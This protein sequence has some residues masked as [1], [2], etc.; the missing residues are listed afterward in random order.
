[1]TLDPTLAQFIATGFLIWLSGYG[2]GIVWRHFRQIME[3]A[4]RGA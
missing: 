4:T 1:M 3:K 2:V